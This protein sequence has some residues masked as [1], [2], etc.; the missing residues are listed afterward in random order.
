[1]SKNVLVVESIVD[2]IRGES[3][4]SG[5]PSLV[6]NVD[7]ESEREI[8]AD[9]FCDLV[10]DSVGEVVTFIGRPFTQLPALAELVTSF[11]SCKGDKKIF[12]ET[13]GRISKE[14]QQRELIVPIVSKT[15]LV[16]KP[17]VGNINSKEYE[18][19]SHYRFSSVY[20]KFDW[21]GNVEK[22]N[23]LI[24]TFFRFCL[25]KDVIEDVSEGRVILI[26]KNIDNKDECKDV[27]NF[28]LL[29]HIRYSGRESKRLFED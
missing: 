16:I 22:T 25:S 1:M 20:W 28:C 3:P 10:K 17:R 24:S 4:S 11:Y 18:W 14:M 2:T 5:V 19:L 7:P 9:A 6:L 15:T 13:S 29:S 12:I 21:Q 8:N 27:W 26:P 23:D